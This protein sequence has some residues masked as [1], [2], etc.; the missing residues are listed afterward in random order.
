MVLRHLL[1]HKKSTVVIF[2]YVH[3][4]VGSPPVQPHLPTLNANQL[5]KLINKLIKEEELEEVAQG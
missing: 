5:S 4:P 3:V 1:H 2:P